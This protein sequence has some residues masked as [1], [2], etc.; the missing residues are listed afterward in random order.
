MILLSLCYSASFFCVWELRNTKQI[1]CDLQLFKATLRYFLFVLESPYSSSTQL[2]PKKAA[3]WRS[4][5]GTGNV[6]FESAAMKNPKQMWLGSL[7]QGISIEVL[8][9][10]WLQFSPGVSLTYELLNRKCVFD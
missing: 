3:V 6:H 5:Q 4:L 7:K 8:S 9:A 2:Y 10:T 1:F